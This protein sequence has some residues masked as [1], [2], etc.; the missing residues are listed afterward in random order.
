[1]TKTEKA[2]LQAAYLWH[3]NPVGLEEKRCLFD[4]VNKDMKNAEKLENRRSER[5]QKGARP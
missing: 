1:M 4:A 3:H 5:K 2:V